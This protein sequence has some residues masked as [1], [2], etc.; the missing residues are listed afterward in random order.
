M[1]PSSESA[2]FAKL[3]PAGAHVWSKFVGQGAPS[4]MGID[5]AA[6]A[7]TTGDLAGPMEF[8]TGVLQGGKLFLA[9]LAP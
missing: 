8:G 5:A 3:D 7:Y 1:V 2:F 4:A 6:H 9:K